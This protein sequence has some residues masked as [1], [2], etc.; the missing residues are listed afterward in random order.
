MLSLRKCLTT[1]RRPADLKLPMVARYILLVPSPED[2]RM[3]L[4]PALPALAFISHSPLPIP[5]C[6]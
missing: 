3:A 4:C 1:V 5:M 6:R 2:S